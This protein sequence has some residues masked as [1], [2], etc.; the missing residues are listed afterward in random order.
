FIFGDCGFDTGLPAWFA[1]DQ[2]L[3]W[4]FRVETSCGYT[5]ELMFG[6][7]MAE[8]LLVFSGVLLLLS[9]AVA[10]VSLARPKH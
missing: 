3:P 4:M 10:W 2:W 5:P 7:T 8:A 6:I 1:V 9:L